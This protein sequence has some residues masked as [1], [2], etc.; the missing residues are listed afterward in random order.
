LLA[1]IWKNFSYERTALVEVADGVLAYL[2]PDA[3][4]GWS[5]AGLVAGVGESA[6]IDID[7]T[8]FAE[9]TDRERIV[10]NVQTIWRELEPTYAPPD[11]VA[12][13]V[14]VALSPCRLR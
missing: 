8:E 2:Q 5:N 11:I 6:L 1:I 12:I 7:G 14:T 9:W 4:S 10:V 3:I 13:L